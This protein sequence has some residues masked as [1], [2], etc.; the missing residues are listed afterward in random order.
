MTTDTEVIMPV[1]LKRAVIVKAPPS[2]NPWHHVLWFGAA[3][4]FVSLLCL[5]YGLDLSPGLF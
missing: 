5:S 2:I 1:A 4:I 3:S